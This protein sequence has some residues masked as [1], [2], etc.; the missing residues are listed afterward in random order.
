MSRPVNSSYSTRGCLRFGFRLSRRSFQ[1]DNNNS[2]IVAV[3]AAI[4]GV[5]AVCGILA[6]LLWYRRRISA[7]RSFKEEESTHWADFPPV[8]A[9]YPAPSPEIYAERHGVG[10]TIHNVPSVTHHP[11][12]RRATRRELEANPS[13]SPASLSPTISLSPGLS[14]DSK[15]T[16]RTP[17]SAATGFGPRPS[18]DP[19]AQAEAATPRTP[20]SNYTEGI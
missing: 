15:N 10:G 9:R 19:T 17:L 2:R 5:L 1:L 7:T 20:F 14:L 8:S 13:S 11:R 18:P 6:I 4:V 12:Q 3:V 16:R